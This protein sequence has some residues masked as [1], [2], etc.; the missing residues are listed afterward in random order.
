MN[1]VSG[2]VLYFMIWW[3]TILPLLNIGHRVAEKPETGHATSAPAKTRLMRT[4]IYNTILSGII[5]LVIY[6]LVKSNIIS[7]VALSN[8]N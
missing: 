8:Y 2:I 6:M 4:V 3:I 1:P 5:W 7:F